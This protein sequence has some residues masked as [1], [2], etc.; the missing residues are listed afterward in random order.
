VAAEIDRINAR[1]PGSIRTH[2]GKS[3]AEA[4][5]ELRTYDVLLVNPLR[6]GMNI[7]ALEG[8]MVTREDS[9]FVDV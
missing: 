9:C 8:P 3:R 6:D 4:L 5:G 2:F 1:F 7:V